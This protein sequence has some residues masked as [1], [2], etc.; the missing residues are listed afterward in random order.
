LLEVE[1]VG[2]HAGVELVEEAVEVEEKL[3]VVLR[4]A[5]L[6]MMVFGGLEGELRFYVESGDLVVE[7]V[8]VSVVA[9]CDN[10][11]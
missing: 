1:V 5:I 11:G 7:V 10:G 9:T 2:E 4:G 3:L 6:D 8:E